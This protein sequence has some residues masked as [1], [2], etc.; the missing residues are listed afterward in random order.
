MSQNYLNVLADLLETI[1]ANPM[2][3]PDPYD[4]HNSL[5]ENIKMFYHLLRWSLAINDCI[6]GLVTAYYLGYLLDER[7]ST[8]D[9]RTRC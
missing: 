3:M 4:D 2:I 1:L 7:A 8:S 5:E 9:K 6:R